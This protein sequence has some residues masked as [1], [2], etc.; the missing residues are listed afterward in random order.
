MDERINGNDVASWTIASRTYDIEPLLVLANKIQDHLRR[1]F[2][3]YIDHHV[4][5]RDGC[6]QRGLQS[7]LVSE[8]PAQNNCEHVRKAGMEILDDRQRTIRAAVIDEIQLRIEALG[9]L[10]ENLEGAL[11]KQ[12]DRE[13][14][15][16]YRTEHC[17]RG[18]SSARRWGYS[19]HPDLASP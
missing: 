12:R 9:K 18:A 2:A 11:Q 17:Y 10:F 3:I 7:A 6:S 8:V 14:L 15:I 4:K 1:V 5:V 16:V 13:L 19:Y